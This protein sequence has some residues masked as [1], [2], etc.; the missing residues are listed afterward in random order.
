MNEEW[1]PQSFYY[2]DGF[3]LIPENGMAGIEVEFTQA[4]EGQYSLEL[5]AS[6]FMGNL[7]E[8]LEYNMDVPIDKPDAPVANQYI[9]TLDFTGLPPLYTTSTN[10][11]FPGWIVV[12]WDDDGT[13]GATLQQTGNLLTGEW[14]DVPA[15]LIDIED[16]IAFTWVELTADAQFFRLI[17]K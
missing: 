8:V 4:T 3:V 10:K 16:N 6:D 1:Q 2:E 15:D 5:Q 9:S 7:S 14:V 13:L 11:E 17:K 12:D